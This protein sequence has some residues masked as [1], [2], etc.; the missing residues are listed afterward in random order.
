MHTHH[1]ALSGDPIH[2]PSGRSRRQVLAGLGSVGAMAVVRPS[3]ASW[4]QP[5]ELSLG[6]EAASP[7]LFRL[8]RVTETV[9]AAVAQPATLVNC[10]A[11]IIVGSDHL[12]VVDSHS[13]PSAARALLAQIRSEIGDRPV[14]YIINTHFH[15]DHAQGNVVY[16]NTFGGKVDIV[17]STAT[18]QWLAR[19]GT[20]RLRQQVE[21]LSR[22][23]DTLRRQLAQALDEDQRQQLTSQI[24][25]IEAYVKEMTPPHIT[26]PTITFDDRLIIHDGDREIHLL[27]LGRGHTA[28]DVV[29][30][31]PSER[32]V[33]TGDLLQGMLPYLGD[34]YPEEW[35][36]TLAALQ[37]L[38]FTRVVP[39]HGAVEHD[40]SVVAFMRA[41]IEELVE[42]VKRG[43][44]R[45]AS[46]E[47]LRRTLVPDRFR[48]L[49][50]DNQAER[51]QQ[52]TVAVFGPARAPSLASA[53]A[54]TVTEVYTF[55]TQRK[56]ERSSQTA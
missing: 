43:I 29:V 10:N 48:S 36:Q 47:E 26:L 14:R 39:G 11:A 25:E 46:V 45:G 6:S 7:P 19:E 49:M 13:K 9:Y 4:L 33:A 17:S 20:S 51:V 55:F 21:S 35:P 23:I 38:D 22:Q 44:E 8:E 3:G 24:G 54:R 42:L 27:F 5:V 34:G 40:K 28:G 32:V 52:E 37:R 18:R 56:S 15:W 16:P 31:V 12:L 50:T 1:P 2:S 30:Y 53:V 41:Y